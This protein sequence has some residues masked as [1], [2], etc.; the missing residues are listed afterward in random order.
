MDTSETYIEMKV[1]TKCEVRKHLYDFSIPEYIKQCEKAEEIQELWKPKVGDWFYKRDGIGFG[2]WLICKLDEKGNLFCSGERMGRAPFSGELI[3]FMTPGDYIWLPPQNQLQEMV[4]C[5]GTELF[6]VFMGDKRW[7]S[8]PINDQRN[9]VLSY[10][11]LEQ[12]WLAFVMK[13]KYNK[14]WNGTDWI[15]EKVVAK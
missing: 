4:V 14:A 11:T 1:C 5:P 2:L 6:I 13:Q 7:Y 3:W 12:L 9:P 10:D 15:A 8:L